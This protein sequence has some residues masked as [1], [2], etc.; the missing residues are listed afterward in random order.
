MVKLMGNIEVDFGQYLP[1]L[2]TFYSYFEVLKE[3]NYIQDVAVVEK[4]GQNL[5]RVYRFE[6][7]RLPL[8]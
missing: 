7:N 5:L 6:N 4:N 8:E 2:S 3:H 1:S